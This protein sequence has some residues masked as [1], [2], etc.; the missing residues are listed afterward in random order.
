MNNEMFTIPELLFHPSDLNIEET[1]I[2]EAVHIVHSVEACAN[3]KQTRSL[4]TSK[5][6][7]NFKTLSFFVKYRSSTPFIR[8]YSTHGWQCAYAWFQRPSVIF[9]II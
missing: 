2:P 8:Q 9:L 4:K 6:D 5:R 7:S 1:G 3:G